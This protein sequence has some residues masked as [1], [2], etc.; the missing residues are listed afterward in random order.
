MRAARGDRSA[1]G[2]FFDRHAA[3]ACR[4]AS[5]LT[6]DR[7]TA[8]DSVHEA[9]VRLI[10]AARRGVFDPDRG[11]PRGLLFRTVRNICID[12]FRHR[13]KESQLDDANRE[14]GSEGRDAAFEARDDFESLIAGITE[15]QRTALLLRVDGGLSYDE[16]ATVLDATLPQVKTWIFRAR[17]VLSEQW[18][19]TS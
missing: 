14:S 19:E 11:T 4:Y 1:F 5:R 18:L 8:E 3:A 12:W 10:D 17:R 9:F 7:A 13:A 15:P 16:I 2:L 6:R